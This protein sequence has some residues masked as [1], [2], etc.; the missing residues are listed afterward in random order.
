MVSDQVNE[1]APTIASTRK[2]TKQQE[3]NTVQT[4][5]EIQKLRSM[6]SIASPS[7]QASVGPFKKFRGSPS[8]HGGNSEF[9]PEAIAAG[10]GEEFA[11]EVLHDARVVL[12][13]AC[14]DEE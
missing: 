2:D 1:L 5:A 13:S 8:S 3:E 9:A 4:G 11:R 6:S 7:S 10:V 12:L 14:V